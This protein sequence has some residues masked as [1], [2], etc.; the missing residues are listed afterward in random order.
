MDNGIL[1]RKYESHAL[2]LHSKSNRSRTVFHGNSVPDV[3]IAMASG[4]VPTATAIIE[5]KKEYEAVVAANVSNGKNPPRISEYFGL[6]GVSVD[7]AAW[8]NLSADVFPTLKIIECK[9]GIVDCHVLGPTIARQFKNLVAYGPDK[10]PPLTLLSP[11]RP[12]PA[13]FDTFSGV[14]GKF[15]W[16]KVAEQPGSPVFESKDSIEPFELMQWQKTTARRSLHE[17]NR[18]K[19]CIA[20]VVMGLG[21][22]I[23]GWHTLQRAEKR[24]LRI[25]CAHT[26]VVAKA[27]IKE[28]KLLGITA[29]DLTCCHTTQQEIA[30]AVLQ[31][32]DEDESEEDTSTDEITDKEESVD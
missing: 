30:A 25:F 31:P 15:E 27:A 12:T 7:T 17:W 29:L 32:V 2:N 24:P 10:I 11:H 19:I 5:A 18:H 4:R 6:D 26:T 14:V 22:T 20:D 8:T 9:V 13:V 21:K 3:L 23:A 28:A 1:G 16:K